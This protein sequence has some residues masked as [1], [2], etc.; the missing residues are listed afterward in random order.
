MAEIA[1]GVEGAGEVSDGLEEST[2]ELSV[3]VNKDAANEE[4]L[5]VAQ[6][7]QFVATKLA[8]AQEIT[9]VTLDGKEYPLT[10]ADG[11]DLALGQQDIANLE[12]EVT[13]QTA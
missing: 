4:G 9:Q 13:Q 10:V 11:R 1:R 7:Y 2:P 5:T 3:V 6:V 8:G 12:I